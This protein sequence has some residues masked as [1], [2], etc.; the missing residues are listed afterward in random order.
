MRFLR[1]TIV[2]PIFFV[3]GIA[4]A[5]QALPPCPGGDTKNVVPQAWHDCFGT[6]TIELEPGVPLLTYVGD[7]ADGDWHGEGTLSY[8]NTKNAA[9]GRSFIFYRYDGQFEDGEQNGHGTHTSF[10][11]QGAN[12]A[13]RYDGE[14]IDGEYDGQG[15]WYGPNGLAQYVGEWKDGERD[16]EGTEYGRHGQTIYIGEWKDGERD[17]EGTEYVYSVPLAI[18]E[19][20]VGAWEDGE[21]DGKGI[22]YDGQGAVLARGS[23]RN[24]R[25][26]N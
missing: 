3:A 2:G 11:E 21:R 23:W 16:G 10:D 15:T 13:V 26:L 18:T 5:A 7:W 17:G 4:S 14:W 8:F 6:Y 20:Y 25:F 12:G 1:A 22:L 24:G 9:E 19:K